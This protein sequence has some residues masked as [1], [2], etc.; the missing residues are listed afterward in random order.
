VLSVFAN[1][2]RRDQAEDA[3]D[4]LAT[5]VTVWLRHRRANDKAA[6]HSTQLDA[7]DTLMS[8]SMARLRH[9]VRGLDV[10]Q[11]T[12]VLF[13]ECRL[14]DLRILWLRRVWQYFRDKFDQRDDPALQPVLEAADEVVWSCYQQVYRQMEVM[15]PEFTSGPAPLPYIEAWY[16]PE[17]FPAELVPAGL[18]SEVD[19]G[20]LREYLNKLPIP[21]VRLQPAC[22]GAPWWLIYLG[23]EVGHHIQ[24]GVLP[25]MALTSQFR[26]KVADAALECGTSDEEAAQWQR[27]STEIFADIFAMLMLGSWFLWA[28]VELELQAGSTMFVSRSAYPSPVIRLR[29]L[30]LAAKRLGLSSDAALRGLVP[31]A[32]D[33]PGTRRNLSVAEQVV[34]AALGPLTGLPASLPALC[35]FRLEDHQA[36][37]TVDN[38]REL[39][40]GGGAPPAERKLRSSRL[41]AS[42]AVAAWA[43][44]I[45]ADD[46]PAPAGGQAQD[47]DGDR[48]YQRRSARRHALAAAT[49]DAIKKN[50][51]PGTRAAAEAPGIDGGGLADL[52]LRAGRRQ[53]EE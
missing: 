51:E 23:H 7:V 34:G 32:P 1:Q 36:G 27:W 6:H 43:D 44:I 35:A 11:A 38:W 26:E 21:V 10:G 52:L 33:D 13:D 39:L 48:A 28:M 45:G 14:Y 30:A 37:G 29:L 22:A 20:F 16:A 5:E 53:L 19:V 8:E 2:A 17:A 3:I 12:G 40:S 9:A 15:A 31:E 50:A 24:F 42:A 4:R 46:Q 41:M 49:L 18:K 25:G 47:E